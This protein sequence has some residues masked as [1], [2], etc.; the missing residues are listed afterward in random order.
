MVHVAFVAIGYVF[1]VKATQGNIKEFYECT[2]GTIECND[3]CIC[4]RIPA[5]KGKKMSQI[6]FFQEEV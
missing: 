6:E 3:Q 5:I 4:D 1:L 2:L